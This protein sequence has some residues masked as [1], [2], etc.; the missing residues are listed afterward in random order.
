MTWKKFFTAVDNSGLPLNVTGQ[1]RRD[2]TGDAGFGMDTHG[3]WLPAVY[4]G[5]PN[6]LMR[7]RQYDAMDTDPE[8]HAALD[9]IAEFATQDDEYQGIPFEVHFDEDPSD[10]ESKLIMKVLKNWVSINDWR[11][12][13]FKMFRSTIKYGDCFMIRDP[14]TYKLYWVDPAQV[15]KIV[16]NQ[17]EG[18]SIDYIFV[19]NLDPNFEHLIA[20]RV[21][22]VHNVGQNM[23]GMG[24]YG[25]ADS[26]N[27]SG[28]AAISSVAVGGENFIQPTMSDGMGTDWPFGN[29]ILD[30]IYKIY[31]Q[32]EL[33]EDAVLIYRLHRAPERRVFFIDVGNMPTHQAR[34]YLEQVKYEVKQKRIPNNTADGQSIADSAYNPM[35]MLEDYFFAQTAEGRGS[36][37]DTLPGG[38]NLGDIDDLKYFNNKLLRGLGI[39]SSYLPTGPEDGSATYND[40]KVGVAYIQEFRFSKYVERLQRLIEEVLDKEFKMYLKW[41]GVEVDNGNFRITLTP[42]QNFGDY[43]DIQ[44]NSERA[45]L[46]SQVA[47]ITY[48][49]NQFKLKKYLGLSEEEIRENE[50]LW[51]QE[52]DVDQYGDVST[53]QAALR[54]VGVR[55]QQ[56]IDVSTDIA[57]PPPSQG[58]EEGLGDLAGVGGGLDGGGADLGA[59]AGTAPM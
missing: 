59:G 16:V 2:G 46:Y 52:N 15:E 41:R 43:R 57:E 30:P 36:K 21:S 12:R 39:P 47:G 25:T 35:S 58:G 38:D 27:S 33:L 8:I 13:L 44:I 6:R 55:P 42:P 17:A 18:K 5:S 3:G 28:A 50:E 1:Q 51:R 4:A 22:P 49:S 37:V 9:T 7:Y 31:R 23:G 54:N 14:E 48:M 11:K 29:S 20:T 32:K 56:D 34:Q 26:Y 45:G 10:T 19:R 40:G 53:K 24:G